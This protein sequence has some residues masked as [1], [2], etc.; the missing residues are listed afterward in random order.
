MFFHTYDWYY[1]IVPTQPC[2]RREQCQHCRPPFSRLSTGTW[3]QYAQVSTPWRRARFLSLVR[4]MLR[5][6]SAIHRASYLGNL[7]RDWLSIVWAH[8]GQET[9]NGPKPRLH[10][11]ARST[12][13]GHSV[14]LPHRWLLIHEVNVTLQRLPRWQ[15]MLS[16]LPDVLVAT[17]LTMSWI[18]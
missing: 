14:D 12:Q 18:W 11:S 15:T 1:T 16:F 3:S 9:E 17:W 6:R 13:C 10:Y 5:L 2:E 7:T 4:S 8:S